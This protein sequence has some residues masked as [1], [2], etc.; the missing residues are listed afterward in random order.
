MIDR[1]IIKW[2]PFDSCYASSKILKEIHNK[3]D[4]RVFPTLS[5]DQLNILEENIKDAY[6]LKEIINIKYYYNG[7]VLNIK[8]K[9]NGINNNEK[10]IYINNKIIYIKQILTINESL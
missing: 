9:I 5:E 4:R 2:Q 7:D 6:H 10:K 3:K 8:G 1:G